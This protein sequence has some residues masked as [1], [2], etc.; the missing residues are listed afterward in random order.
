M[1][2]V[3]SAHCNPKVKS[4][5][6]HNDR[7]HSNSD[8]ITKE[9]SYKN[10]YSCSAKETKEKINELYKKAQKD[11][12]NYCEKKNGLAKSG[13]PKGLQ[14]FTKKEK[15]YTEFIYEINENTTMEQ[16]Q[17][18]SNKIAELTGFTP[19]Q[20]CIHRDEVHRDKKGEEKTHYHAH[21]VF[22]TLDK[23][24][25]QLARREASLNKTNLSKIQTLASECLKMERGERRYE[26]GLKQKNYTSHYRD[27]KRLKEKEN[28]LFQELEKKIATYDEIISRGDES[29]KNQNENL[30]FLVEEATNIDLLEWDLL[31]MN[32]PKEKA[33]PYIE[34][35]IRT[36][37]DR[38]E[39]V[40]TRP[41][42]ETIEKLT[43]T[44]N[45][46]E[47]RIN[48]LETALNQEKAK[49][50]E[51]HQENEKNALKREIER[52]KGENDILKKANNAFREVF[53]SKI[54]N[55]QREVKKIFNLN[56]LLPDERENAIKKAIIADENLEKLSSGGVLEYDSSKTESK[57]KD[58]GIT[59][60]Q[61]LSL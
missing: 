31:A 6:E 21:A 13:K 4:Y 42:K 20:I 11:F 7:T 19:L 58:L 33:K 60:N 52:L 48:E 50:N 1:G 49:S 29:L 26:Q 38:L 43:K 24:G 40:F 28:E 9:Y 23:D 56:M 55:W 15:S 2:K 12:Y 30:K 47:T 53:E 35:L 36:I 46:Q 59:K 39:G 57:L 10:E 25:L 8:T 22:F 3:A 37:K 34:S 32:H 5:L 44:I 54:G 18:L 51:N 27:Y 61:G 45:N 14:N 41:L 16:C 17:E